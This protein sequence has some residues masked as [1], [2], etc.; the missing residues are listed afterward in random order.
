[1]PHFN[2]QNKNYSLLCSS[3]PHASECLGPTLFFI[4]SS[5]TQKLTHKPWPIHHHP[6][7][8]R[9]RQQKQQ[10]NNGGD[11]DATVTPVTARWLQRDSRAVAEGIARR[12][13]WQGIAAVALAWLWRLRSGGG[14]AAALAQW[15]R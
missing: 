3:S 8:S 6:P 7:L 1:M 10:H 13:R 9:R 15:R 2:K 5:L 14:A 12:Q 4:I 11:K